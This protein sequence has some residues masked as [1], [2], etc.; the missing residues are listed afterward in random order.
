VIGPTDQNKWCI[1]DPVS[2]R[3]RTSGYWSETNTRPE[4]S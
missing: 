1:L 2:H 4:L 3:S